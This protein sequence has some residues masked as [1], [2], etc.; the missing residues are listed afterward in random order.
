MLGRSGS[1]DRAPRRDPFIA[2]DHDFGYRGTLGAARAGFDDG[3][4][5]QTFASLLAT[6]FRVL[7]FR[8][9]DYQQLADMLYRRGV[10]LVANRLVSRNA[11]LAV[12]AK[13]AH[14]DKSVRI[15]AGIDFL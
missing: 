3:Y 9:I 5:A 7:F 13:N 2:F 6:L 11:R 12:I 1:I 15:Q 8:A 10:E 14:L 4:F